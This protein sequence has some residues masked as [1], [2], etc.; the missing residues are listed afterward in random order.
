VASQLFRKLNSRA[1][2]SPTVAT[3][4]A[5]SFGESL[6]FPV[7]EPNPAQSLPEQ[8]LQPGLEPQS[9]SQPLPPSTTVFAGRVLNTLAEVSLNPQPLTTE[10]L[11]RSEGFAGRV[12]NTLAEVSLNPQP[13]PPDL[14]RRL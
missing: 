4:G 8:V 3:Q 11:D 12:L 1:L 10:A 9:P 2:K 5:V 13:L 6:Q 14:H 7:S